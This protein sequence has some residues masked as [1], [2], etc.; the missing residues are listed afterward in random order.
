ME[1]IVISKKIPQNLAT[2]SAF[3]FTKNP[4][5]VAVVSFSV[6]KWQNSP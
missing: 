1:P 6:A 2:F 4:L 5:H 3:F